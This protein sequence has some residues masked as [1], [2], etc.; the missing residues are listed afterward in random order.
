MGSLIAFAAVAVDVAFEP[1]DL[2]LGDRARTEQRFGGIEFALCQVEA[3]RGGIA[4]GAHLDRFLVA[5][6]QL[7]AGYA[8]LGFELHATGI[9]EAALLRGDLREFALD[10]GRQGK[11]LAFGKRRQPCRLGDQRDVLGAVLAQRGNEA[12]LVDLEQQLILL[13]H[14]PLADKYLRND[15]AI[16]RLDDLQLAGGDDLA[17]AAR[18]LIHFG[19]RRPDQQHQQDHADRAQDGAGAQWLL[20]QARP[21][22][23]ADPVEILVVAV[24]HP[25]REQAVDEGRG[26]LLRRR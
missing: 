14:L 6:R 16:D 26:T 10:F 21:L 15:S 8:D 20:L 24:R 19:K 18:H 9:V 12:G 1:Q 23:I 4:A 22:G 2:D 13:D 11:R 7:L 25:A 17:G 3:Q 5:L